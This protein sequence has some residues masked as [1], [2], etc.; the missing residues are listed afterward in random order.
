MAWNLMSNVSVMKNSI[1][2]IT[3]LRNDG[4][5]IRKYVTKEKRHQIVITLNGKIPA[6]GYGAKKIR[7]L[8]KKWGK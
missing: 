6:M 1:K 4:K 2:V 7:K 3:F 8:L 5:S